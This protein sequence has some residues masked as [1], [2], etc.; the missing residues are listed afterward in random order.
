MSVYFYPSEVLTRQTLIQGNDFWGDD[1]T[2]THRRLALGTGSSLP[3]RHNFFDFLHFRQ[4]VDGSPSISLQA[5][6]WNFSL[7]ARRVSTHTVNVIPAAMKT[8]GPVQ[9]SEP[10]HIG[11][12]QI[13]FEKSCETGTYPILCGAALHPTCLSIH[14]IRQPV[15][16]AITLTALTLS[17][18]RTR[19]T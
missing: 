10:T 19:Q 13:D 11:R 4:H 15:L 9:P 12:L 16:T 18:V 7:L 2:S 17:P 8:L 14:M 5:R 3:R 6:C 1:T